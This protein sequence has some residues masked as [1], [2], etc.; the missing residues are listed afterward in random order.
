MVVVGRMRMARFDGA[1][2]YH[3]WGGDDRQLRRCIN[4]GELFHNSETEKRYCSLQQLSSQSLHT[5]VEQRQSGQPPWTDLHL[6]VW[7]TDQNQRWTM[8]TKQF[9]GFFCRRLKSY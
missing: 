3:N 2:P 1:L 7:K 5:G 8:S 9:F 4:S 6:A